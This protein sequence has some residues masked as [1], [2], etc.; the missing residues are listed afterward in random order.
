[1]GSLSWA[2]MLL[3][4]LCAL[5]EATSLI[6][7]QWPVFLRVTQGSQATLGCRVTQAGAWE[8]LRVQWAK[9]S[10]VMCQLLLTNGTHS[11]SGC[12]PRGQLLWPAPGDMRLQLDQ[13]TLNDSGAYVCRAT[14]EIPELEQAEGNQTQLLVSTGRWL[15]T[16]PERDTQGLRK[17]I[18]QQCLVPAPGGPKEEQRLAWTG[19]GAGH[20][21]GG[22]EGPEGLLYLFPPAPHPPATAS[23]QT[24]PQPRAGPR[25]LYSQGLS[26]PRH[27]K[28]AQAKR[29]P[30]SHKRNQRPLK[31]PM[32]TW[33]MAT[34][35][36][37]PE[38]RRAWDRPIPGPVKTGSFLWLQDIQ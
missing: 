9:D 12:G 20:P 13:L 11:P 4:L 1:M 30:Q 24:S 38:K 29:V 16:E 33:S 25:H 23:N 15:T 19:E 31:G 26:W 8:R 17:S 32:Q 10:A 7:Q 14:V 35:T 22:P 6:V 2:R 5:Q 3:V 37:A 21:Q 28:I 18:L 34:Y 27:L 36:D